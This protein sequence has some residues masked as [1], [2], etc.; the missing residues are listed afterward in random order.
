MITA[1]KKKEKTSSFP[2]VKVFTISYFGTFISFFPFWLLPFVDLSGLT[3]FIATYCCLFFK[4]I[5]CGQ[6]VD[7]WIRGLIADVGVSQ[8]VE[9][10]TT[11]RK[12]NYSS[13]L[14]GQRLCEYFLAFKYTLLNRK[15]KFGSR[16]LWESCEKRYQHLFASTFPRNLLKFSRLT[17]LGNCRGKVDPYLHALLVKTV[18]Q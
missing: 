16:F 7:G 10:S 1:S 11:L 18:S 2:F 15:Q 12:T 13:G 3:D 14:V 8:A 4:K 9:G 5:R 17:R 6:S